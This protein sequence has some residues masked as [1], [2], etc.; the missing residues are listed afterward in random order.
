MYLK[1]K[2]PSQKVSGQSP[3]KSMLS[4]IHYYA[5]DNRGYGSMIVWLP[6][7]KEMAQ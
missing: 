1:M 2:I 7:E 3:Q 5:W 4:I 6:T